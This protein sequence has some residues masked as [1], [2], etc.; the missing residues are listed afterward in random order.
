MITDLFIMYKA[1]NNGSLTRSS[2]VLRDNGGASGVTKREG[3]AEE[4]VDTDPQRP[5]VMLPGGF[6]MTSVTS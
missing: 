3:E 1:P 5:I 6:T 4:G 2:V